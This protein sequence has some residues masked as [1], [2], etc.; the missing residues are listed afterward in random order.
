MCMESP[1]TLATSKSQ[2]IRGEVSLLTSWHALW[3]MVRRLHRRPFVHRRFIRRCWVFFTWLNTAHLIASMPLRRSI[4]C[5]PDKPGLS[6]RL[7][8]CY[9]FLRY[10]SDSVFL[11]VFSSCFALLGLF[12]SSLGS[13]NVHLI[14][15]LVPLIAL[16]IDHQNHLKWYKWCHV[17]YTNKINLVQV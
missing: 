17:R 3:V 7:N 14:N 10:S 5:L 8:R 4:W 1:S 12:T 13:R 11:W 2:M 9:C 16:S 15:L 6:H